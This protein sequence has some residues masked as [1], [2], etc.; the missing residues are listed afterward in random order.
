MKKYIEVENFVVKCRAYPTR[1][2]KEKIDKVLHGLR[3]AYNATAYEIT[4]GNVFLTKADK[5]DESVIWP[6]FPACMKKEW[7]DHLRTEYPIVKE[8]PATSLSSSVY[9]IFTDMKKSWET[10]KKLPCGKWE[11]IYYSKRKP[12]TSFTVQ[13]I[14]TG[15]TFK[16]NSKSVLIGVSGMGKVKVRGWRFDLRFGQDG[17]STFQTF[18]GGKENKKAFGVT[19]SKDNCGDYW[20]V[21]KL[22]TVWVPVNENN[23]KKQVGVDVGIKD[24]AI[25][26]EGKKYENKKFKKAEKR[27]V[28]LLHRK[29]SR[30]QGWSNIKFRDAHKKNKE[31]EP[32]AS[33]ERTRIKLAKLER[34]IARR[35]EN[36]N[37][38][39]TLDIVN[40]A[41]FI[42]IES[43]N[44]S[45]MMSN[46]HL[47]YALADAA[48][49][50]V[51]TKL[52]YKS[53]WRGVQVVQ[54]GQWEPSTKTCSVC[55][56]KRKK[57]SLSVRDWTCPQ[58][59]THHDRDINAAINIRNFALRSI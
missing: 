30:R 49:S 47:A 58:C 34:K 42:G 1:I 46:H 43:L 28:K 26:S 4:N 14:S 9:G 40:N 55:G 21:V 50:D 23:N 41:S 8:V 36:Y 20:I 11:P 2:Q 17:Q 32:S 53:E 56:F 24:I 7:L 25:T 45:G 3:V 48:M 6:N 18:Y 52:K 15:F 27:H 44:V 59:H 54:I 5:K 16:E 29:L 31:L 22:Q 37:H 35:R 39:V 51:L 12:R 19:V 10:S 33:Y 38:G 13:T 57:M